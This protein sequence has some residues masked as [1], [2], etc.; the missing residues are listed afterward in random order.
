MS[1]LRRHYPICYCGEE[2][3]SF[4]CPT[5]GFSDPEYFK[6]VT[7]DKIYDISGQNESQYYLYTTDKYR[8]RRYGGISLGLVREYV[9][10]DFGTKAR[11]LFGKIGV[12][13]A[14]K[15]WYDATGYH[16]APTFLNVLNNAILR[17]NLPKGVGS[18]AGYGITLINHP[19]PATQNMLST[20]ARDIL[21]GNEVLI[22]IFIIVAMSFVPAS[23]ALFVVYERYTRSS[24]LQLLSGVHPMTYLTANYIWDVV[25]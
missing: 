9:P 14:A 17:A 20:S 19:W 1:I 16:S 6:S 10:K 22:S 2:K 23:F 8:L 12:R 13:R 7:G 18:P 25:S 3:T 11:S 21:Q 15:V 4:V 24:H 5:Y